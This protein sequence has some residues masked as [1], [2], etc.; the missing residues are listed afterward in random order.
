M[1]NKVNVINN[2]GKEVN[3]TVNN[4]EGNIQIVIESVENKVKLSTLNPGDVFKDNNGT[5]YIVCEQFGTATAVVRK[6]L[7]DETFKFG[8]TNNWIE[9][10]IRKYLSKNYL[11]ELEREFGANNI[12][13]HT[14]NLLSMDGYDDYGTVTDKVSLT[15]LDNYRKYHKYI[16]NCDR[17][18]WLLTPDSTPSGSN[19]C[20]V[21]YVNST[22]NVYCYDCDWERRV[23]PFFVLKS[24]IMV[25]LVK[26]KE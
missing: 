8:D 3:V 10:S 16:G 13:L 4:V 7:L 25:S 20:L 6:K 26:T 24:S 23:R 11:P 1:N 15:T 22:G 21:R 9:S 5:E 14:T 2:V 19:S 18:Y 12:I 17:P